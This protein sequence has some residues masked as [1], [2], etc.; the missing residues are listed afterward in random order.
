MSKAAPAPALSPADAATL[1]VARLEGLKLIE[2]R[3]LLTLVTK[4]VVKPNAH[5]PGWAVSASWTQLCQAAGLSRG[6]LAKAMPIIKKY[7][8]VNAGSVSGDY[9]TWVIRGTLPS[10]QNELVHKMNQFT[11][12]TSSQ[13]EHKSRKDS[14][15]TV[16]STLQD[17][18]FEK[19]GKEARPPSK[20][21]TRKLWPAE[22]PSAEVLDK[23]AEMWTAVMHGE[24]LPDPSAEDVR[25]VEQ[26]CKHIGGRSRFRAMEQRP[27]DA[28]FARKE[29]LEYLR[30][31]D[32]ACVVIVEERPKAK[33]ARAGSRS[34]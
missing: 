7:A 19:G 27:Q 30:N 34:P 10:S 18:Q 21:K 25:L 16:G 20:P 6:A 32:P 13:N 26:A 28:S 31:H 22:Q 14:P 3:L 2:H 12:C 17:S 23:H 5:G 1:W 8:D 11:E 29:F 24:D 15:S 9:N 33:A 4:F